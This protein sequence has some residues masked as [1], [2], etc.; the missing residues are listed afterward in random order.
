[1]SEVKAYYYKCRKGY[2]VAVIKPYP[3]R[4]NVTV[5]DDTV[6]DSAPVPLFC[7]CHLCNLGCWERAVTQDERGGYLFGDRVAK[8]CWFKLIASADGVDL[9]TPLREKERDDGRV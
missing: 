5:I 8:T 9:P 1:M 7:R 6:P 3:K 2:Q 4:V